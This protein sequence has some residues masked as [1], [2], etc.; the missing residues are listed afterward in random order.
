MTGDCHVR[1]YQRLGVK[2]PRPTNLTRR[3]IES[4]GSGVH[5]SQ[6]SGRGYRPC[7]TGIDNFS[8]LRRTTPMHGL[9]AQK[10]TAGGPQL[11]KS[12]GP[13]LRK[14]GGTQPRKLG[15]SNQRKFSEEILRCAMENM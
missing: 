8:G 3:S 5:D 15:G 14:S 13:E 11:R 12:G 4:N 10:G 9:S 2:L 7:A 1:F 6:P